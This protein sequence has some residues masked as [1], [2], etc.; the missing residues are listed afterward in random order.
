MTDTHTTPAAPED[1]P[2]G[3]HPADL[4]DRLLVLVDECRGHD[5]ESLGLLAAAVAQWAGYKKTDTKATEATYTILASLRDL[6]ER[7][8]YDLPDDL[9]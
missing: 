3:R 2:P 4:A 5:D 1:R 8:V 7:P 6:A 9:D